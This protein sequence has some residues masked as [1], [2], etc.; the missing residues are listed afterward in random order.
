MT[1]QLSCVFL[2]EPQQSNLSNPEVY[3]KPCQIQDGV[4]CKN[5]FLLKFFVEHSILCNWQGS[6]NTSVICYS[7]FGKTEDAI[8]IDSV[9][10]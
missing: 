6:E 4:F 7:L 3:W 2:L 9:A 10:I 1:Y 5:N 8:K